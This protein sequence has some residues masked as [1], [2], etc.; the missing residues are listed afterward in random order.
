MSHEDGK[1]D[2]VIIVSPTNYGDI[3]VAEARLLT[4]KSPPTPP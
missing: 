2:A 1:R 3:S 4:R